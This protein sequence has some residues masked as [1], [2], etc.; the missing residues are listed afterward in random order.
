VSAVVFALGLGSNPEMKRSEMAWIARDT[1]NVTCSEKIISLEFFGY[2][3]FQ[4][5]KYCRFGVATPRNRRILGFKTTAQQSTRLK[6]I[7]NN[8]LKVKAF[9]NFGM[10][11][12]PKGD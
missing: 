11:A 2:F 6:I 9:R 5:K 8:E 12:N 3:L 10:G 7:I 4:D 1:T